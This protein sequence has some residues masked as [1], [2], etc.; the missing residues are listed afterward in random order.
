[1]KN[2]ILNS[3]EQAVAALKAG[4]WDRKKYTGTELTGKV[5]RGHLG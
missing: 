4:R 1:L 2:A 5:R 3:S